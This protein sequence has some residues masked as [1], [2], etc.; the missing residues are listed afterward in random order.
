MQYKEDWE[1]S[2]KR[3]IAYWNREIADH[4]CISVKA[5][6]GTPFP[7]NLMSDP[8]DRSKEWTDPE[9]VIAC[10]RFLMEHTYYAGEAYPSVFVN[11]GAAGH[12]GFFKGA[13]Y[14]FGDT[15]WFFPSLTEVNE[16]EFDENSFLTLRKIQEA[17]KGLLICVSPDQ[18]KPIMENL[19][20]KGLFLAT[21]AR[22]KEEADAIVKEV[23]KLTH[24]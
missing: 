16:L 17:G 5:Y 8:N 13:K 11:L 24:E 12:V 18:I 19:S 21:S 7:A 10:N 6:D 3:H 14:Q 2:Q 1:V 4:C 20:S 22:G 23:E 9:F 15:V